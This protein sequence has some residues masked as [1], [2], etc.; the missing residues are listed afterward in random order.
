MV[1][2]FLNS[3]VYCTLKPSPLHGI[4]VFAIRDIPKGQRIEKEADGYF[5]IT[6]EEFERILPEIQ[7]EILERTVFIDG[8]P[9]AFESPNNICDFRSFMNHSD[10][11]NTDGLYA[12]RYIE[13]GEELTED[14]TSMAHIP[15]WRTKEHMAFLW[16]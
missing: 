10:T 3:T 2:D 16:S 13:R 9:L 12:L 7:K 14:F 15:H 5:E 8:E 4:G 11:P 1:S 6:D